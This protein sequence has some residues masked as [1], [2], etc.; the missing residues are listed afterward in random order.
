MDGPVFVTE[1]SINAH[2][3]TPLGMLRTSIRKRLCNF[4]IGE[5]Y[6][7]LLEI[8]PLPTTPTLD[9]LKMQD[10]ADLRKQA[11]QI[12][13]DFPSDSVHEYFNQ[14]GSDGVHFVVWLPPKNSE[15]PVIGFCPTTDF[16]VL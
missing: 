10:I 2:R 12:V 4:L 5:F 13:D 9:Q 16:A 14:P 11:R 3:I 7:S 6:D 1:F 15:F 8:L